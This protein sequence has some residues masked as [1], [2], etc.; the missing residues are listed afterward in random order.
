[1]ALTHVPFRAP[2]DEYVSQA[3]D[4]LAGWR[5]GD[6]AV[7]EAVRHSHPRFVRTDY[8]WMP[9]PATEDEA[10][11]EPFDESDAR[12]VVARAYDF[13]DWQ[14]LEEYVRAVRDDD[15]PVGRFETAVEAVITGA[16][17]SLA[18]MLRAHPELVSARS[19]RVTHLDP[20]VHGATL[21]HYVAANGVEGYRQ[22]SPSNAVAI[23]NALLDAGA[24]PDALAAMYGGHATTMSMLVSSTP[25]AD[26]G[27]QVA[28]VHA[29]VDHGASVEPVGDGGWTSPL[30]TALT[31]AFM[32]AAEA[33]VARGARIDT[34]PAAAG[35][36]IVERARDLLG[37]ASAD[38]RHR[39]LALAAQ[40]GHTAVV[41][42]LLDA[43]ESPDRYNPSRLHAH[44]TPLHQAAWH[45]H[46]GVV[47]LL[48]ERG[49][50]L[51]VK[52]LIYD[53]TPL[54]WA[55]HAGR[56]AIAEYLRGK[57]G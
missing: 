8:P 26:A 52:D 50:R 29:L 11:R 40:L 36:G 32:P 44:T 1:M 20:Q 10:R 24:A 4:V 43:G 57:S 16:A 37:D 28:L 54:D 6:P 55:T 27:V 39:A 18:T 33:L 49:T 5:A 51:D 56:S 31:F 38:D 17:A 12:L 47:R 9:L 42:M 34:L 15:S 2:L 41:S 53:G 7:V 19:T 25:P 23:A 45:G 48:V 3:R 22:R 35:L 30:L 14:R 13:A 46:E 21:L